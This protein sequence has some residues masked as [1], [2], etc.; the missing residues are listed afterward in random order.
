MTVLAVSQGLELVKISPTQY[1][2][3]AGGQVVGYLQGE[4]REALRRFI[5]FASSLP[6]PENLRYD[7]GSEAL[8]RARQKVSELRAELDALRYYLDHLKGSLK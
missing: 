3:W 4:E 2:I 5:S 1:E 8:D 7:A 6:E